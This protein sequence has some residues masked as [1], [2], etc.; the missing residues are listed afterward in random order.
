MKKDEP[1]YTCNDCGY[2][3]DEDIIDDYNG[4]ICPKCFSGDVTFNPH[5]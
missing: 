3:F 5:L 4:C 2:T 1:I